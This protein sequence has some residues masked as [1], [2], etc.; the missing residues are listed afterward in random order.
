MPVSEFNQLLIFA[1]MD[2]FPVFI[3]QGEQ[4]EGKTT[5]LIE[6]INLL[7]SASIPLSG[8]TAPGKWEENKRSSFQ[9][10]D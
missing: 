9:V 1:F 10:K 2:Q 7:V 8:F 6:V 4:G 5:R 3:I